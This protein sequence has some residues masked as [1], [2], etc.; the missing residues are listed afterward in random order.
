MS[1]LNRR[2]FLAVGALGT[3]GV[4]LEHRARV[5]TAPEKPWNAATGRA[6][7]KYRDGIA[8]GCTLCGAGCAMKVFRDGDRAVQIGP[9]A[10]AGALSIL[11][12]RAYEA[13]EQTYDPERL[14]KPL[15]RKGRRGEGKWEEIAWPQALELLATAFG[16]PPGSA[17][18]DVG[19][20]D[21]LAGP[22]LDALGVRCVIEDGASRQWA[23][24]QAQKAV[25]GAP[26][27]RPDLS[28]ARTILLLGSRPLDDSAE[29]A[30][31][32]RDLVAART[33]GATI[34]ALDAYQGVTGS[35]AT[36]WLPVRPGTEALVALGLVRVALSQG[37]FAGDALGKLV[38]T[39]VEAMTE[40]LLP[41]K[42]ELVESA[43]G[44]PILTL[45]RLAKRLASEGPTLVLVDGAG[46][47][48]ARS[49][50]AAAAV[51]NCLGGNPEA[52]GL[53][54]GHRPS[55]VPHLEPTHPRARVIK[56]I[57][58]GDQRADLYFAYRSNPLYRV[59]RSDSVR[60]AFG[61]EDRVKLLVCL[62]TQM[63]E[64]AEMAD[65]VLPAASD[66]ELWNLLGGYTPEGKAWA[67]LQQPVT[68]RLPEG[69]HL[70]DPK[71]PVER[72]FDTP[73][74]GPLG[75]ARQLGD[76]LLGVLA[77]GRHSA[78]ARFPYA[79]CGAFVR[80]L[81]DT[82]PALGGFA[83]LTR[84]GF[85]LGGEDGYPWAARRGF[86]AKGGRID[87][88]GKLVHEVPSELRSLGTDAFAL[89][90]LRYP[91]LAAAYANS[92]W[93]RE[94]RHE[95]PVLMNAAVARK[96]GLRMGDRVTIRTQVAHAEARVIP[97]EGIHPQA[98]ALADDF[99]H[100][101]G[102]VA[103]TAQAKGTGEVPVARLVKRKDF[104]SNPLGIARQRTAPG[105]VPWW[106]HFGPGV[107]VWA[108]SP[109]TSD[110][111]G[112]QA[113]KEIRVTIRPA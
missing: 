49:L 103:A 50:E 75:E 66:L 30:P 43:A 68:R 101:A 67:V 89:V 99:G 94:I 74:A 9:N 61:E 6:L 105:E 15:R 106:Q 7:H 48:Q 35:L 46:S 5:L 86:P 84:A 13:L 22:I 82:T 16:G 53:R 56:D 97:I 112:A 29:F 51:L 69:A 108:L 19:R 31:L 110:D 71:V 79:D 109:F 40:A 107:S 11:C 80:R 45:L 12:A 96:M 24:R 27:G 104:L 98:V 85:R 92:R 32:A 21:P 59:A 34:V 63:T 8:T 83:E 55:Y 28:K 10:E 2:Q 113:W 54:L 73:S 4:A 20:P 64:T 111:L 3:A 70:T 38:S 57:L 72:L 91:E 25:Y 42:L 76:V 17:C 62:D 26:L 81:A 18:A 41:Y 88:G 95:N 87:A 77:A 39:P 65:L 102:G 58:A 37:W 78:Q 33:R 52:A 23:A 44:I 93:G 100:W 1:G 90:V 36:E 14:L 60:R 47:R